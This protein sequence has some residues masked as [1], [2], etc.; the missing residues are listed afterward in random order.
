MDEL[1]FQFTTG[2]Y[3]QMI[4]GTTRYIGCGKTSYT[5]SYKALDYEQ[6]EYILSFI[7]QNQSLTNNT[8][9]Y[10]NNVSS[11]DSHLPVIIYIY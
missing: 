3:T 5:V 11:S 1:I 10:R 8:Y 2:H 9:L 4:W 6:Q 7:P